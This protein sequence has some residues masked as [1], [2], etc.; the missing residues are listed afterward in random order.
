MEYRY[1][2][3]YECIPKS[4]FS[5]AK[6]LVCCVVKRRS[7]LDVCLRAHILQLAGSAT[8]LVQFH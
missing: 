1:K 7:Q 4:M 5:S 3:L 2:M 6:L 8:S